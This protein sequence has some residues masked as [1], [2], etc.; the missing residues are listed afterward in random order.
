MT[1]KQEYGYSITQSGRHIASC[2]DS[3]ISG[4][5]NALG[6]EG[7]LARFEDAKTA[8]LQRPLH[9][10]G[11]RRRSKSRL[12]DSGNAAHLRR[13]GNAY[14]TTGNGGN[15]GESCGTYGC[16]VV[17]KVD[18]RG[19]ETVLTP[20]P[21]WRM[22]SIPMD[23]WCGTMKVVLG[24]T[25]VGGSTYCYGG[26]CGTV[27]KLDRTGKLTTLYSFTGGADGG[28]PQAGL[29][30]DEK[31]NSLRNNNLRRFLGVENGGYGVVFSLD[32]TGKETVLHSF[33]GGLDGANP[34]TSLVRDEEGNLSA[35][36][37]PVAA[38]AKA[39]S[40]NWI[41]RARR[42][43]FTPSPVSRTGAILRPCPRSR[44]DT[45]WSCPERI[46]KRSDL[47]AR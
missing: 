7:T 17:F 30:R 13:G 33:T 6:N 38:T 45:L 11:R 25:F 16:G 39:S 2:N 20:S 8:I 29:L 23:R 3:A 19:K 44:R 22:D 46:R 34:S 14:A 42:P 40:S 47:Q 9:A 21:V 28:Y 18:R 41:A 32:R 10:Y 37:L 43:C 24:T 4:N 31:E 15:F 27:F 12:R 1:N 5:P 26:G 36:L 35:L